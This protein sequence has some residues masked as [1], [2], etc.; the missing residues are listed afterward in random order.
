[1]N[2]TKLALQLCR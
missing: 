1:M 2:Y